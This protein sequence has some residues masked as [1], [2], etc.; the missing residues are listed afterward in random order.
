VF[1]VLVVALAA[2]LPEALLGA[3]TWKAAL[4]CLP[5]IFSMEDLYVPLDFS[6]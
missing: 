5:G 4:F 6:F 1:R 3:A 2:P